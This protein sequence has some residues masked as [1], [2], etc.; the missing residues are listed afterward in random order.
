MSVAPDLLERLKSSRFVAAPAL[1]SGGPGERRSNAT[2]A[3]MEF[4]SY[5]TYG[6]GDDSRHVDPHV[7][8][9]TGEFHVRQYFTDR[10]LTVAVLIDGSASMAGPKFEA[11]C[12]M[13]E[14]VG[15]VALWAGDRVSMMVSGGAP[16]LSPRFAGKGRVAEMRA[17]LAGAEAGGAG[18][19][20]EGIAHLRGKTQRPGLFVMIGDFWDVRPQRDVA[21]LGE[22]RHAVVA[23]HVLAAEELD[24]SGLGDGE[25]TLVDGESG[26]R[27]EMTLGA[28]AVERYR[29]ALEAWCDDLRGAIE[30]L[31]GRYFRVSPESDLAALFLGELRQA[32]V[33]M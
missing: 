17:W 13:A 3:G 6:A 16:R 18:S 5:R 10:Q 21:G 1:A 4:A 14:I 19:M 29:G 23:L 9:R 15:F 7:Y 30:R 22:D 25:M 8:A 12:R 28:E 33:L 24:P 31:G 27:C 26:S 32:R 11:A 2:G 20:A